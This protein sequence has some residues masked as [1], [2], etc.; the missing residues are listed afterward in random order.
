MQRVGEFPHRPKE[1]MQTI[2]PSGDSGN[3]C[4]TASLR[5]E[6]GK[7]QLIIHQATDLKEQILASS[8]TPRC[9][10]TDRN[11]QRGIDSIWLCTN[12]H[13]LKHEWMMKQVGS[14]C[15]EARVWFFQ[16]NSEVLWVFFGNVGFV[17]TVQWKS[18]KVKS[19][20]NVLQQL[21]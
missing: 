6:Y 15:F 2:W 21:S 7:S 17:F 14:W 5:R 19:F 18:C 9:F 3:N 4:T 12:D 10:P 8:G 11:N 1:N 20:R 16:E 13:F